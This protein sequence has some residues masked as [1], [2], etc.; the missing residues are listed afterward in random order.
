M[1]VVTSSMVSPIRTVTAPDA[2]WATSPVSPVSVR[3]PI[4]S[5]VVFTI[6]PGAAQIAARKNDRQSAQAVPVLRVR[7][8]GSK[9]RTPFS[10]HQSL[11][12]C[13][14]AP[15]GQAVYGV[16]PS[17]PEPELGDD[18][19]VP[20]DVG[21]LQ[22]VQQPAALAD[23][24]Q[25]PAPRVVVV[26]V[27]LEMVGEVIDP[28][29]E[30]RDLDFGRPGVLLVEAVRLDHARL[31]ACCQSVYLLNSLARVPLASL[32]LAPGQGREYTKGALR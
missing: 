12:L 30:D 32:T 15:P 31:D 9:K 13:E 29:A 2:C 24:L 26:G 11:P 20:L 28:F 16:R 1:T 5:C 7:G 10:V 14:V 17:P 18:R 21:A 8:W 19:S 23:Q 3:P 25:Q 27:R 4:S 22:I 6:P